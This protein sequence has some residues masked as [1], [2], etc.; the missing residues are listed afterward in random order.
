MVGRRPV[1]DRP[2]RASGRL[3]LSALVSLV[4][5]GCASGRAPEVHYYRLEADAPTPLSAPVF[6]GVLQVERPRADALTGQRGL[7]QRRADAGGGPPHLHRYAHQRWADPPP[8]MLE[9]EIASWLR[10]AGV[11]DRVIDS[12]LRTPADYVLYTRLAALEQLHEPP[13][14][15]LALELTVVRAADEAVVLQQSYRIEEP[16]ARDGV[17]YAVVAYDEAL[18]RVL[19]RFLED[20]AAARDAAAADPGAPASR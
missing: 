11:A 3:A 13:G 1:P 7:V 15:V 5:S 16:I 9:E 4:L 12:Q 8:M 17:P 6:P 19:T 18:T 2:R 14:I 10:A 20:A